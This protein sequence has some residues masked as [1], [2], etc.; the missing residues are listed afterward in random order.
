MHDWS[1]QCQDLD[2]VLYNAQHRRIADLL[3]WLKQFLAERRQTRAARQA[4]PPVV[5]PT[6]TAIAGP[7]KG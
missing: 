2:R 5:S 6:S 4:N 7:A 3:S 1:K